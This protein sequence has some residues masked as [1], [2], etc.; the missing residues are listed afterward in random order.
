MMRDFDKRTVALSAEIRKRW[1]LVHRVTEAE[2]VQL[3]DELDAEQG[4]PFLTNRA[5]DDGVKLEWEDVSDETLGRLADWARWA[6][7]QQRGQ[8]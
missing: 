5:N 6:Q 7:R 2:A 3:A 4:R 1:P 8:R